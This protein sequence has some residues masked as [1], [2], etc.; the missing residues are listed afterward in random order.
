MAFKRGKGM[1]FQ[2]T[3]PEKTGRHAEKLAREIGVSE[4]VFGAM[5]LAAGIRVLERQHFPER[6]MPKE[7]VD[8]LARAGVQMAREQAIAVEDAAADA[9]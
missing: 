6:F 2:I 1:V 8:A 5:A 4:Q 3:V 7:T 9:A